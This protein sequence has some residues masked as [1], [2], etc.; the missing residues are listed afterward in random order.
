MRSFGTWASAA[1]R[2]VQLGILF[3]FSAIVSAQSTTPLLFELDF[4]SGNLNG[5]HD[6]GRP[7]P[8]TQTSVTRSGKYAVR[9]FLDSK[10][11]DPLKRER[12]EMAVNRSADTAEIGKEFWYGW[13]MYLAS[14]YPVDP[15]HWEILTQFHNVKDAGEDGVAKNPTLD[16]QIKGGS[17]RWTIYNRS[18]PRAISIDKA[19]ITTKSYDGGLV[20]SDQWID[21]VVNV[22]WSYKS[23]GFLKVWKNGKLIVNATGP[24]SFNDASGPQFKM[25]IY[26]ANW[27]YQAADPKVTT[28]L[29]YH[30]E[31]RM[32]GATGSY[33]D[34]APGQ[35]GRRPIP[36]AQVRVQ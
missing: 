21:W 12:V 3:S 7:T 2:F 30:D 27:R 15:K 5:W 26:K 24:T 4:E 19:G 23:D 29:A 10:N 25:G 9:S 32:A 13:S 18:D 31:F 17:N 35:G 14:P 20:E 28:R 36:P 22:K 34:V 8:Q 16:F 6:V 33:E 11:T 1:M